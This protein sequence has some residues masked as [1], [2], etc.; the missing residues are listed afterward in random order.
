M[1]DLI[2]VVFRDGTFYNYYEVTPA[3]WQQF[4]SRVSKGQYI[5]KYLDFKPRGYA[6]VSQISANAR[7]VF[8]KFARASQI[9]N[10]G[11]KTRQKYDRKK[12]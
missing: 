6:D 2:T 10:K 1:I 4:K 3:E 9:H 11:K 5:Y 12:K 7:K 8:Y